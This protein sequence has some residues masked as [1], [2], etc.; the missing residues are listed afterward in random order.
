[1]LSLDHHQQVGRVD[2][3]MVCLPTTKLDMWNSD[4]VSDD[5]VCIKLACW[6]DM[7]LNPLACL[8]KRV[9][10]VVDAQCDRHDAVKSGLQIL[11]P[12]S[13]KNI[14]FWTFIKR[15]FLSRSDSNSYFPVGPCE[16]G[17]PLQ[18]LMAGDANAGGFSS[19]YSPRSKKSLLS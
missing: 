7:Y 14:T 19:S 15:N 2:I 11:L 6:H 13:T 8:R 4:A 5:K 9:T 12:L 3:F 1:M 10:Q 17:G 18:A 16:Y